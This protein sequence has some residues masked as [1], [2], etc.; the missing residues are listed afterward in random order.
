MHTDWDAC[1]QVDVKLSPSSISVQ[2]GERSAL[3]GEFFAEI[4]VEESTWHM[5]DGVLHM[6]LLKR[7]RRGNYANGSNNAATFWKSVRPGF[8]PFGL[9]TCT[10]DLL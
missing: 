4:K 9:W 8:A 5:H 3:R 7:N 2:L 1:A 6:Q 10:S